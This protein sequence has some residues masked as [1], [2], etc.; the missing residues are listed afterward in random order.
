MFPTTSYFESIKVRN[1]NIINPKPAFK[2]FEPSILNH[3]TFLFV[4]DLSVILYL[5]ILSPTD[6]SMMPLYLFG[7][8]LS[9][10]I[11]FCFHVVKSVAPNYFASIYKLHVPAN[12]NCTLIHMSLTLIFHYS[13]LPDQHL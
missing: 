3:L 5:W 6:I 11:L 7:N 2:W 10:K 13:P 9:G 12:P 8:S 1:N 4:F